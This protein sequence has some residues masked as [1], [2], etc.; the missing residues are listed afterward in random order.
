M[1]VLA[2]VVL[3]ACARSTPSEHELVSE[4]QDQT[5]KFFAYGEGG[6]CKQLAKMMQQPDTCETLVRQFIETK[7]HLSRVI[8]AKRDGR[9]PQMVLVNVEAQEGTKLHRWIVRAKW[10]KQGWKLAL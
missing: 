3:V 6:D 8:D 5:R 7:T 9:D 2:L 4:A 1:R 10:T